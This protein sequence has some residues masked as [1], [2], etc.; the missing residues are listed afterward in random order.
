MAANRVD[1]STSQATPAEAPLS[2]GPTLIE[3]K[4][5]LWVPWGGKISLPVDQTLPVDGL[6]A[7]RTT[8][9]TLRSV[10]STAL[11]EAVFE[12]TLA[13]VS[14]VARQDAEDRSLQEDSLDLDR[15]SSIAPSRKQT[16]LGTP[17]HPGLA[18]HPAAE[19]S[20]VELEHVLGA[21]QLLTLSTGL[22]LDVAASLLDD[23]PE[24]A[25]VSELRLIEDAYDSLALHTPDFA[26]APGDPGNGVITFEHRS[27]D[28]GTI[29]LHT[30]PQQL[31]V[32]RALF[33]GPIYSDSR[34]LHGR[35]NF[36]T[37]RLS[38]ATL[39]ADL[40]PLLD[41]DHLT[42]FPFPIVSVDTPFIASHED[43]PASLSALASTDDLG[44]SIVSLIH[45]GS[46]TTTIEINLAQQ[47]Q[48]VGIVRYL[49]TRVFRALTAFA[50]GRA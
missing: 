47:V 23:L 21:E 9:E 34:E 42:Q 1:N 22:V 2:L 11:E 24:A 27:T 43:L 12:A 32:Q 6:S 49:A 5:G 35:F 36:S 33:D 28:P 8:V 3:S 45:G 30:I 37:E 26:Q 41:M 19:L 46:D 4:D 50:C 25:A 13:A 44:S 16:G 48:G 38:L 17:V 7:L 18:V 10:S 20:L 39:L 31:G 14:T 29:H 40:S 15:T